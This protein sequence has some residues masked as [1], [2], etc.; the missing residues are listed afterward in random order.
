MSASSQYLA[1][2][3]ITIN[4]NQDSRMGFNGFHSDFV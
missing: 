4:Q 3:F 1:K 2:D